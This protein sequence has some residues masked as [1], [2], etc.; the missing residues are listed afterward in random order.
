LRAWLIRNMGEIHKRSWMH[1]DR[2]LEITHIGGSTQISFVNLC[3]WAKNRL[4][5]FACVCGNLGFAHPKRELA[6]L[7]AVFLSQ[8]NFSSFWVF[9]LRWLARMDILRFRPPMHPSNSL[10]W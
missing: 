6:V 1:I 5:Q 2:R 4:L 9:K 10:E 7:L 3:H 8:L